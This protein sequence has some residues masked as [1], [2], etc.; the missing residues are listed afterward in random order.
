VMIGAIREQIKA[1]DKDLAVANLQTMTS[2][3]N[4]SV[5]TRRASMLILAVFALVAAVLAGVGIYGVLS[6]AVSQRVHEIGIRLALGAQ[7][8]DVLKLVIKEGMLLTLIGV[9]VGLAASLALTHWLASL[10]FEI[11]ATD[12]LTFA[13]VALLL[14]LV[15]LL[16]CYI[17]A[18][19]ATRTDPMIALRCE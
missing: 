13:G 14:A 16:A 8:R 11:S 4:R 6:Y 17:P 9:G 7:T 2:V 5:A 19:R 1:V 18:R 3:L 12:P 15:A 10:L